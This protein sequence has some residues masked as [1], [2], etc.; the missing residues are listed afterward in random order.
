[1]EKPL[2]SQGTRDRIL[3]AARTI[4][5]EQ[6]YD[7]TTIRAVATAAD[8]HASMVMRYYGN[9]EG[10][11]TAAL[12]FDLEIPDLGDV[13]RADIGR[14]LV[15][16]ALKRWSSSSGDLPAL[17]RISVTHEDARDRLGTML[18]EQIAPALAKVCGARRAPICA[19]FVATQMLGL[20]LTRF[21]LRLPLVTALSERSIVDEV[22]A[23]I[24]GYIDGPRRG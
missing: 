24:Q 21:V 11:F 12:K 22:G 16:H 23:K 18:E 14:T 2:R 6:G 15:R 17:L 9:K 7:R 20:A 13:D 5:G 4:F 10:L 3:Q 1:M 8:I 19:A